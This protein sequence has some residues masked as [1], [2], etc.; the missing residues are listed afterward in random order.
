MPCWL[1]T[2][3]MTITMTMTMTKY[4]ITT[5]IIHF[6]LH[7]TVINAFAYQIRYWV[8]RK[9]V[10]ITKQIKTFKMLQNYQVINWKTKK[11]KYIPLP[12]P[13][14][15]FYRKK[16]KNSLPVSQRTY[17]DIDTLS[18]VNIWLHLS[19]ILQRQIFIHVVCIWYR[20]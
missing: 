8:R 1:M 11:E 19:Q 9:N 17:N 12:S 20:R 14:S 15:Q 6:I 10:K 7:I 2:M 18:I 5:L 4:F 16:R 3:T 13:I